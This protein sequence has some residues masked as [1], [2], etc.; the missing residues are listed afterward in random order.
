M[1]K[2]GLIAVILVLFV[3]NVS[4]ADRR[5]YVWTYQYQTM[6]VGMTELEFYQTTKVSN[7]STWE[8]RLEFE[9]GITERFDVGIYQIFSQPENGSFNWDAFQL[10]FRYRFGETGEYFMD[11]LFY[12]E[13]N[14]KINLSK[15][16]KIEAKLIL[17]KDIGNVN[18]SINPVY[19]FFF[20][21]DTKNEIGLDMG[22]SYEL[23]PKFALGLES[24]S[25][26]EFAEIENEFAT[27]LGPT[28]SFASGEFF[29]NLGAVF[30]VNED[31]NKVRVRY[32]M[33]ILL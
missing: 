17:A 9:H 10:R 31:A 33:G 15:Q 28:V 3:V 6:P 24:V 11:P 25:R 26:L 30:G 32:I 4:K 21:P 13:Y 1:F 27:Y 23:S 16:N 7:F 12:I 14:R 2:R 22:V 18:L 29:F 19:E 20:A 8:Y 5:K